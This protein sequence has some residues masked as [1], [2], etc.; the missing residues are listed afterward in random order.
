MKLDANEVEAAYYAVAGF[1]RQRQLEGRPVQEEVR[2]VF[3]RLDATVRL[4]RARHEAGCGTDD[5]S[6]SDEEETWIGSG[7]AAQILGW[8]QR[9]VQRHAPDMGGLKINGRLFIRESAVID[10]AEE[11]THGGTRS[12]G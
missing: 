4:S 1:I 11:L 6:L 12:R 2:S 3:G 5:P 9:K 10:Y 8:S 7:A